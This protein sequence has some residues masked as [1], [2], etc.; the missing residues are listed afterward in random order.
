VEANVLRPGE[1]DA[2]FDG[3]I[4]IK[5]DLEQLTVTESLFPDARDGAEPHFHRRHADSF[6]VLEGELAL[7]LEDE[8][9]PLAVGA[10]A[11]APAGLVHGFRSTTRTRFLN[12]HTPDGDFAEHL[13]ARNRDEAGGFDSFDPPSDMN[14]DRADAI[15]LAPGDGERLE[16][17][18]RIATIKIGRSELSF[19][20][21]DLGPGF[22]GPD[23]HAHD[24]HIDSFYVVDGTPEFLV[25]DTRLRLG[26]GSFVAAPIGVVHTFSNPGPERARLLNV[27]AP[28]RGFHEFL[29]REG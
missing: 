20:E 25:G 12:F 21:F 6:Y 26:A 29:R 15:A 23:P 9:V 14:V 11:S 4:V 7:L 16:A 2:L 13:R 1:G 8:E 10:C 19:V 22:T 18:N 3:R 17:N 27:H 24:D 5:A 28:S